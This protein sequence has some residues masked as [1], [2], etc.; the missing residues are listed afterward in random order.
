MKK[1]PIKIIAI[2]LC[3][4]L[5]IQ[6]TG[7]AQAASVELNIAGHLAQLHSVLTIDKFRPLHLRYISY[8]SLNNNFKL[9]LDKGDSK[10]EDRQTDKL[11]N[12]SK[13][14]LTYFFTGIA[15]PNDTFWVNLR[16]DSPNDII[17]PLLAQTEVGRILLEADLQ[18]KK[19][20]AQA[21]NPQTL[22]GRDYWNKLYQKA[23][24]DMLKFQAFRKRSV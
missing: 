12:Q 9:L 8:D 13:D 1:K 11:E 24:D 15:L 22:E 21:T 2:L 10:P 17:D 16:P 4:L 7:F 19:D 14:L 18:L 23:E 5:F 20:T 3:I 6:Q